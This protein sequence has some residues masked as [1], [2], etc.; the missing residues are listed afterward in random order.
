MTGLTV[1]DVFI[2]LVFIYLLYSL[3]AMTIIE[4]IT[5]FFGSRSKNLQT[6]IDRLLADDEQSSNWNHTFLNLFYSF[7]TNKLTQFFYQH[8]SIKYLGHKG[9]NTKPSYISASRFSSTLVDILKKGLH[10]DEEDNI[11]TALGEI[12]PFNLS[13][14]KSRINQLQEDLKNLKEVAPTDDFEY[15]SKKEELDVLKIDLQNRMTRLS[16]YM[17]DELTIGPDTKYQLGNLWKEA[18]NDIEKFQGLINQWYEEQMDRITGWYKR[19]VTL[20][21]FIIGFIIAGLFNVDTIH[22]VKDLS[23]NETMR[24]MIVSSAQDFIANNPDGITDS[25]ARSQKEYINSVKN[26]IDQ[27]TSVLSTNQKDDYPPFLGW[28]ISAFAFSLGA[29]FWFDMLNKLMKL[30][31]SVQIP[32]Q[33]NPTSKGPD[34]VATKAIG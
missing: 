20:L 11:S 23:Q 8:P 7:S 18:A 17:I 14:L 31:P 29:P 12:A 26:E 25:T 2:S 27:Y 5:T 6:G 1:L 34:E 4:F 22:L 33:S 16:E 9:I 13:E 21:T 24:T 19:K 32:S 30:R 28:I 15:A 10:E 3:F